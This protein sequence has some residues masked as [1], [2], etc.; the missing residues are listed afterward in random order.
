MT[1]RQYPFQIYL[2]VWIELFPVLDVLFQGPVGTE[3]EFFK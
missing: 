2:F 3:C 1:K